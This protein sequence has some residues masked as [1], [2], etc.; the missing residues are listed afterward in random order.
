[1]NLNKYV[2]NVN[3]Y[4]F[5]LLCHVLTIYSIK[6]AHINVDVVCCI[7]DVMF[8]HVKGQEYNLGCVYSIVACIEF[9]NQF[10]SLYCLLHSIGQVHHSIR[11]G[12]NIQ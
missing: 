2:T 11:H 3:K 12:Y 5:K 6:T 1:M 8:V 7:Y 10:Y 4:I 9:N